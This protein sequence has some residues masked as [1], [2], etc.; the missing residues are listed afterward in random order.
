MTLQHDLL[1]IPGGE[2]VKKKD[3]VQ[4]MEAQYGRVLYGLCLVIISYSRRTFAGLRRC[5]FL[6]LVSWY[7]YKRECLESDS[8]EC[9][10]NSSSSV[11]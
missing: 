2:T 5:F 6:I 3:L 10:E 7:L 11:C 4:I 1:D 8:L 9:S